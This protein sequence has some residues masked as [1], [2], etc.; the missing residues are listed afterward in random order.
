LDDEKTK[1]REIKAL[2]EAAEEFGL[3]GKKG[4]LLIITKDYEA[5]ED[6]EGKRITYKKLWK[7]LIEENSMHNK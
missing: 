5:K 7:W 4:E 3:D 2:V 1:E 6:F